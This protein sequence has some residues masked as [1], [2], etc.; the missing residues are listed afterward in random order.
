M[1]RQ[2]QDELEAFLKQQDAATLAGVL[3]ELAQEDDVVLKRLKRMQASGKPAR[4]ATVFRQTLNGWKRSSKYLSYSESGV[5]G[6]EVERWLAQIERELLPKDPPAALALAEGLIESDGPMF[7]RTDDSGGAIGGA[8]RAACR[9][10]LKAAAQCEAPPDQWPQRLMQLAKGDAYGAREELLRHADLLLDEAALR[11]LVADF[12]AEL[13]GVMAAARAGDERDLPLHVFK[14]SARL[15]LLSHALRDPDV[16]VRA[17]LMYSPQPNPLQIESFVRA[18]LEF[19]RP[20]DAMRWLEGDWQAHEGSRLR[21]LAQALEALDR[22]EDAA[23]IRRRIFEQTLAVP[24]LHTW[25]DL[26]PAPQQPPAIDAARQLAL[27]HGDPVGS[28]LLLLDIGQEAAAEAALVEAEAA[29][30]LKGD[31]YMSLV[32]L[33]EALRARQR[34]AGATAAYRALL[35]AVLER[36]Y[37]KAYSYGA[38]Y[39]LQ[40]EGIA[41]Q[42]VDL[43]PLEPHDRFAASVRTRHGRKVA[44]W[45]WVEKVRVKSG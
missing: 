12:E 34:W 14:M 37:T 36:A 42:A 39:W 45:Q 4:L 41:G 29:E 26:L 22:R 18:Y 35:S 19:G 5:F 3:L 32:P 44:F 16:H 8:V 38:S 43:A 9:L 25:L 33:A 11:R 15:H 1:A 10:W 20:A 17:V 24:D 28:A 7:E 21:L 23:A 27:A 30:R 2:S 31:D 40:L 13:D 6:R